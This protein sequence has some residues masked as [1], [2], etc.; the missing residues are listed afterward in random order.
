MA[1]DPTELL[2]ERGKHTTPKGDRR[3]RV[4][5][6]VQWCVTLFRRDSAEP[7]EST[8]RNLSSGGFHC[9]VRR[10]FAIGE[11]L[12][13]LLHIPAYDPTGRETTC[14]LSCDARVLRL[15]TTDS[16]G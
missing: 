8:T 11:R 16:D 10:E 2:H 4:R 13:A 3:N 9:L 7:I 14:T 12:T 5:T 1:I 6:A 15:D